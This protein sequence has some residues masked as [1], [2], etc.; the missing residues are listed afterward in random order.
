M[1]LSIV[2]VNYNVEFYLE[3]CLHSVQNATKN[4]V[5]EI[6]VVDNNSVD[7]S[8]EMLKNKF[9]EVKLI[10]N[11][12]NVGFSKAN[13]QAIKVS[14]GEYVLLLNPDT[15]V[16]DDTFSKIISFMDAHPKAG[17]LGVKMLDG[18]GNFLP[19]SKRGLPTP[20]IAFFKV[21]GLARLFPT[22]KTFGGYHLGYLNSENIHEVDVL[23]G[24]FM[25]LRKETLD[26]IGLLDEDYFMYGEDIDLSYRIT[27]GGYENYYFPETRI[28]HYKGEST[29]KSSINYVFIFYNAM[30]IFAK[31]HFSPKNAR[32]FSFIIHLAIYLRASLSILKRFL[33]NIFVPVFDGALIYFGIFLIRYFWESYVKFGI[34]VHYPTE[35]ITIVVPVYIVIWLTSIY[36]SGGYDKPV[37]MNK[38]FQGLFIGTIIILVFYALV[39]ENL[40]FSRALIL[41]GAAWAF[42]AIFIF[43]NLLHFLKIGNF[44]IG[45]S[46]VKRYVI[47]GN[48][49][50]ATRVAEL[51]RKSVVS[52]SFIGLVH[53]ENPNHTAEGFIGNL[54]QIKDIISIYRIN[55]VIFCAKN[56]AAARIIDLM[57]ELKSAQ[58]QYKIAPPESFSIIGSKSIN[59]PGDLFMVEVNSINKPQN[60]RNKRTFDIIC[61]FFLLLFSPIL[62]FIISKPKDFLQNIFRVIMAKRTLVGYGEIS[63]DT[64]KG[65]T[66]HAIKKGIL[67]TTD[68]LHNIQLD[69]DTI[70]RLNVLYARDYQVVNDLKILMKSIRK[71]GREN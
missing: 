52:P 15:I 5:S 42:I 39:N 60:I 35:F 20:K 10:K 69:G 57:S 54:S 56:L 62:I 3:Q 46:L 68:T 33:Q 7:T 65:Y 32:L 27:K 64:S 2:I 29:K 48:E 24:A 55:E 71:L 44:Q 43:R 70:D 26:K 14:K 63:S 23:S 53:V 13:N 1:K 58:V 4:I 37:R 40:R 49:E 8:V 38:I 19:E 31:K 67:N 25:F 6:I 61:S 12:E 16:E 11:N 59:T 30:I 41:L 66:L 17:G 28:I 9:P 47:I 21:F 36:F 18:K 50:E 45:D 22:T 34:G 51:I